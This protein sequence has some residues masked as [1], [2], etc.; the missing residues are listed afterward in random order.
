MSSIFNSHFLLTV[1]HRR[2]RWSSSFDTILAIYFSICA[3][4]RRNFVVIMR[5]HIRYHFLEANIFLLN[6]YGVMN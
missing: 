1:Y 2:F 4:Y 6:L 5:Y 3:V